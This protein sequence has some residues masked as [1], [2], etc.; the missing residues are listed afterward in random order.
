MHFWKYCVTFCARG[1]FTRIV[2]LLKFIMKHLFSFA[3]LGSLGLRLRLVIITTVIY[4]YMYS[5]L[6]I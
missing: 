6:I 1:L 4:I 3:S 5:I 2:H